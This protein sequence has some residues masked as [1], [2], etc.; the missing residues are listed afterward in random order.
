M[1]TL[2]IT[3][4][5]LHFTGIVY[6]HN[7]S[8]NREVRH[9]L[10]TIKSDLKILKKLGITKTDLELRL[11]TCGP[12]NFKPDS[13][14]SCTLQNIILNRMCHNLMLINE[15][16]PYGRI[17]KRQL[18]RVIKKYHEIGLEEKLT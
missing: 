1:R 15:R 3:V 6:S 17:K 8:D 14:S 12:K 11:A 10:R 5:L 18:E 13:C 4:L 7:R 9:A 2:I 16:L